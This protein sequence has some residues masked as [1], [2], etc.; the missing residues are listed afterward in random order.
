MLP[1]IDIHSHKPA[2]SPDEIV[3]FNCDYNSRIIPTCSV[4]VH[5][6]NSMNVYSDHDFIE[7]SIERVRTK[8]A[9]PEVVAIGEAGLDK[10][11]G[12]DISIQLDLFTKQIEISETTEKP[13]IIHCVKYVDEILELRR[14]MRPKQ[15]WILHGYR[16]KVEQAKTFHSHGIDVSFGKYH[17]ER[18]LHTAYKLGCLWLETDESDLDIRTH[19]QNV[20][21]VLGIDV[22]ELKLNIY[23]RA[24]WLSSSFHPE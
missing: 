16:N 21:N 2:N 11:R 22:E 12:A 18:A 5:P 6:W 17:N 9:K 24:S 3:V 8:A 14:K 20:A 1:Y 7:K 19:Y 10:L 15:K 13:L 4:G 23:N